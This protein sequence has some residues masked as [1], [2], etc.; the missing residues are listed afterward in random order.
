MGGERWDKLVPME[1]TGGGV[2]LL[3]RST[4][5]EK[6]GHIREIRKKGKGKVGAAEQEEGI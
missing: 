3:W 6:D 2:E 5:A 1:I 4:A